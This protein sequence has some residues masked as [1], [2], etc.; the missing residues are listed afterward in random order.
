M[1]DFYSFNLSTSEW[2]A[3]GQTENVTFQDDSVPSARNSLGMTSVGSDLYL[4]GGKS[5]ISGVDRVT[6][7]QRGFLPDERTFF[8]VLRRSL[9]V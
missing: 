7:L 8:S 1:N 5:N 3:I 4:F 6:R 9:Q 2:R